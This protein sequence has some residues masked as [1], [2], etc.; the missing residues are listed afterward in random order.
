MNWKQF[1]SAVFRF[2]FCCFWFFFFFVI[3]CVYQKVVFFFS[4]IES[5]HLIWLILF[6]IAENII[7]YLCIY[8]LY[9]YLCRVGTELRQTCT[10][11]LKYVPRTSRRS[12]PPSKIRSILFETRHTTA[13]IYTR[14]KTT[15]NHRR[16]AASVAVA[17]PAIHTRVSKNM[18]PCDAVS[19]L[20]SGYIRILT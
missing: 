3:H 13:A 8:I 18:Y 20:S 14:Q 7:T 4:F 17:A 15:T 19:F 6:L 12:R 5:Y 1:L 11:M 10:P 2:C 16:D 9:I